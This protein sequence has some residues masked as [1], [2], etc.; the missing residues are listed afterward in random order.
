VPT[1]AP[2]PVPGAEEADLTADVLAAAAAAAGAGPGPSGFGGG[3]RG[4]PFLPRPFGVPS[5]RELRAEY[6]LRK[7]SAETTFVTYRGGRDVRST[8]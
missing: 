6:F 2:V 8:W 7:R 5:I 3:L 1:P 4:G